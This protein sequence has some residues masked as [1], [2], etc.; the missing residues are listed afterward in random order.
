MPAA[1]P[2]PERECTPGQVAAQRNVG[3]L[4]PIHS[5][6]LTRPPAT[7]PN[8]HSVAPVEP[9]KTN[10]FQPRIPVIIG[11]VNYRGTM[12]VDGIICGQLGAAANTLTI[13]QRPRNANDDPELDGELSFKDMLRI[14]GHVAGKVFSQKG[15]L[16]VDAS[17]LVEADIS[18]GTCIVSGTVVGHITGHDRVEVTQGATVKG[19]IATRSLSI[20]PGAVFQGDCRMLRDS[21]S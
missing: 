4:S 11:E 8:I 14:N 18:V 13:K 15:T 20:K 3:V 6:V 12:P 17:A 7:R 1:K 21:E 19:N 16:I 10:N 5:D 9:R 2:A